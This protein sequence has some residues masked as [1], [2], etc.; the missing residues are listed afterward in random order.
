V[1]AARGSLDD[2]PR[3]EIEGAGGGGLELLADR[4]TRQLIGAT[5]VGP[6][7]DS[8]LGEAL[9][10]VQARLAVDLLASVVHA[11]PTFNQV[12]DVATQQLLEQL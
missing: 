11:F 8:W 2:V 10:A 1:V 7:A 5:A 3:T 6:H 12:Y 4:A 9:L